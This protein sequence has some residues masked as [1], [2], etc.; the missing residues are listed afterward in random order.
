ML[1][2]GLYFPDLPLELFTRGQSLDAPLAVSQ[3]VDG[4]ELIARC[5]TAAAA[6]GIRPGLTLQAA[7]A[8]SDAL[9]IRARDRRAERQALHELALWA[10]QFS[11]QISFDPSMLLLEVGASLGLFGGQEKLLGRVRR[12]LP[13][14]GL[15][16]QW[17][18][19]PTP[20]AAGLLARRC[21]GMCVS[22]G[23]LQAALADI[24]LSALTRDRGVRRLVADIGLDSI[25]ECLQLPRAEL[26]RRADPVLMLL[27]DRLLGAAPDPR[28][29]WQPPQHFLQRIELPAEIGRHTALVFPA[30]RLLIGL[31]GFLRGRGAATQCLHWCLLHRETAPTCFEQGLL[32]MSRDADYILEMFRERIERVQLAQPVVA[33]ELRVDDCLPFEERSDSLLPEARPATDRRLL[34]RLRNRLGEQQVQGLCSVPD[35]RPER[36]WQFCPPGAAGTVMASEIRQPPW[37]LREPRPLRV[38]EHGPDYGGP[39]RLRS[40]PRRIESGWWDGFDVARDYFVALSVEGERLWVFCDRRSGRWFLHGLFS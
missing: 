14:L 40:M 11:P 28:T 22:Q 5:N 33:L 4:R 20:M 31:C 38:A 2:L 30:K 35:H 27:F 24:P 26:A 6:R 18:G 12:Q 39:L 7:L 13:R 15:A 1:W 19:A 37:L 21:P 8:L 3:R 25:G 36:S 29:Q 9:Q 23:G 34:E 10:Y 17:A 16:C 32:S